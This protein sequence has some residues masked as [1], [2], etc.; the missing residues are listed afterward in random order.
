MTKKVF[1]LVTGPV[2]KILLFF[3]YIYN[4]KYFNYILCNKTIFLYFE[5]KTNKTFGASFIFIKAQ[6]VTKTPARGNS[7]DR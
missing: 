6:K 4:L 5:E 2:F 3:L 1:S 7:G